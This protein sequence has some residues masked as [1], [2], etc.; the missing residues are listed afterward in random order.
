MTGPV[1]LRARDAEDLAVIAACMQDAIIPI[2]DMCF[3][4]GAR[5]FVMVANRFRW[6]TADGAPAM[7]GDPAGAGGA[8]SGDVGPEGGDGIVADDDHL[9]PYQRTHC[10]LR[11]EGVDAVRTRGIDLRDRHQMLSLLH[12]GVDDGGALLLTFAAGRAIRLEGVDWV[13][14]M[15]DLGEPWPTANRPDHDS[16]T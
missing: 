14:V 16:G 11:F 2:G 4:P 7:A 6:E 12:L 15:E 9:Y 5:R 10:G 13:C 8:V 1:R 3:E